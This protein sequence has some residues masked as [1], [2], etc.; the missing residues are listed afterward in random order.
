[1]ACPLISLAGFSAGD[2]TVSWTVT[3]DSLVMVTITRIVLN[4]P[5]SN[6]ALDR[7]RFD[8]SS[9]WNGNDEAPPSD[10]DSGWTGNRVLLGESSKDLRFE[11]TSAAQSSGYDLDL[12]LNGDCQRSSAG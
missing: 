12:T 9:I 3:N 6:G 11:F 8:S 7:I 5:A 10:V 2:D 1:D 4:W